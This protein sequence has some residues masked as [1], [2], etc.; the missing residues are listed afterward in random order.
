MDTVYGANNTPASEV[1]ANGST[2]VQTE[3]WNTNGTINDIHYYGVTGQAYTDYDVVYGANN[4][5]ASATFSNG[6]TETLTYNSAN[7]LQEVIYQ[8]VTGQKYTSTDTVYGA[9]NTPASEVSSNGTTVSRP[10]PGMPTARSTTSTITASPANPT[11]TTTSSMAPT[12]SR[13][14]DLLQRHDRYIHLQQRRYAAR[15]GL[16]RRHRIKIYVDGYGLRRQQHTG[17]RSVVKRLDCVQTETWNTNGTINDIHYYGI[18]GAYTDYDV[19]YGANNK[20]AS[21][22]YSSGM[23]ETLTY[24]SAN[25]LQ[26]VIYQGV[27]G[28]K[29]T[30]M[31]TVYGA[32]NTPASEVWSNGSTV[33]PD[34][35]LERRRHGQRRPLL[36]HHRPGLHRLRRRLRRQQQG[37]ERDLLRRHDRDADLQQRPARC[38]KSSTRASPDRNTPRCDTVYGANNTPASEVWSN[39]YDGGAD[40]DLEHQRH[41]QRCPLLR[42]HRP[43]LHRLRRSSTAPT[44]RPGRGHLL[45][46]HDRHLHV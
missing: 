11:P 10:R 31:D 24:N 38:R 18:T 2:I 8:S 37:G 16:P 17:E 42:H 20:A 13:G 35:D 40:R 36:R 28:Q 41:D 34:R 19:V 27:T 46:R 5:A 3:T 15:A 33:R 9:N 26:E 29:Y 4:K 21:A 44:T 30:S 14:G 43:G 45:R 6:M 23:T 22:I 1:W 32:N 25:T 39:G 7:T 12:T